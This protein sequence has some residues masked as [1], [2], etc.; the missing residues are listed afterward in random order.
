MTN[1]RERLEDLEFADNICLLSQ[2]LTDMQEKLKQLQ[3]EAELAELNINVKKTKEMR[4]NV[5]TTTEK[6]SIGGKEIEQVDSFTYLG[7]IVTSDA[8]SEEDVRMWIRKANGAFIQLYPIWKSKIISKKTKICVFNTNVKAVLLY[9]CETR[10]VSQQINKR[11]QVF[12]NR[13]LHC[14]LNLRW[15]D[16]LSN[17][18]LWEITRH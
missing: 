6:L 2:R 12:V 9:A 18:D 13:C 11:M 16:I 3:R 5:T 4:V 1:I 14:I 7:S 17:E 15:P 10:K 8:G